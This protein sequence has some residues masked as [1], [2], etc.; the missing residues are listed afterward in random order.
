[1]Q[2]ILVHRVS[3]D[4]AMLLAELRSVDVDRA[5]AKCAQMEKALSP[6]SILPRQQPADRAGKYKVCGKAL[7]LLRRS[8]P[9]MLE[10][11]TPVYIEGDG[12]C[13][14]R[15]VS[16][17]VFGTQDLHLQLRL[18]ACLEVGNHRS[19][20]DKTSGRCHE[21]MKRDILVP[22]SYQEVWNEIS[23]VG[24]AC[25]FV[26]LLA[27]SAVLKCRIGSFFPPLQSAFVSPLTMEIV[28]RSVTASCQ[29]ISVMW[30]TLSAVPDEGPVDINH[31][32]TLQRR[33]QEGAVQPSQ[34]TTTAPKSLPKIDDIASAVDVNCEGN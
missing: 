11:W 12:N 25:S 32:V 28:G 23:S 3:A 17:A 33:R 4:Y 24:Q 13:M 22:P 34:L 1:M 6:E 15:A 7:S 16:Q 27:L 2:I 20:Y 30:S 14:F 5:P 29:S 18:L 10:K 21:L 19:T 8:Q 31:I 26:A 9:V